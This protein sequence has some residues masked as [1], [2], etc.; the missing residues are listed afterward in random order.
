[1]ARELTKPFTLARPQGPPERHGSACCGCGKPLTYTQMYGWVQLIDGGTRVLDPAY[2][3]RD[4]S[5][6]MPLRPIDAACAA[7]LG[8]TWLRVAPYGPG[9]GRRVVYAKFYYDSD[10]PDQVP[11][12]E[13]Y[14]PHHVIRKSDRFVWVNTEPVDRADYTD[15]H[16]ELLRTYSLDRQ[17]LEADE[18]YYHRKSDSTWVLTVPPTAVEE[19]GRWCDYS[20][21]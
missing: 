5:R 7:R 21:P 14:R 11:S 3:I 16:P 17:V 15:A 6:M 8:D 9:K 19:S 18:D 2:E 20:Q 12:H 4:T 1:M 13:I 10:M